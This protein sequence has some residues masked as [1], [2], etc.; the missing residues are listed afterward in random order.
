MDYLDAI[1]QL[2]TEHCI[3][4]L[5]GHPDEI[6]FETMGGTLIKFGY[7]SQGGYLVQA[8]RP[9]ENRRSSAVDLTRRSFDLVMKIAR[10]WEL[11]AKAQ[12]A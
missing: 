5:T 3:E 9:A 8:S 12:E 10:D 2:K 6:V 7:G 11:D 4:I 1:E